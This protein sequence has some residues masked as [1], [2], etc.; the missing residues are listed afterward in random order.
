M[1][2]ED[3]FKIFTAEEIDNLSNENLKQVKKEFLLQFQLTDDAWV[4]FNGH[5]LR[6]Y[7]RP[8]SVIQ[9]VGERGDVLNVGPY[10]Q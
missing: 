7:G 3:A 10:R 8:H 5:R 2:T 9:M 1:T 4:D 6:R